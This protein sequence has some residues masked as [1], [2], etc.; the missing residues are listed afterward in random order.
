MDARTAF[1]GALL[2]AL[3]SIAALLVAPLLQYV[4]AA[5]LL[6]FVLYPVHQRL[7][8]RV[9]ERV[10]GLALTAFA[11]V[12]AVVPI[13]FFSIILLQTTFDFLDGFDELAAIET[14]REAAIDAGIEEEVLASIEAELLSE[15]EGSIGGAV[16][17]VLME[18]V[19]LLN[20]SVRMSFG[21]LVLVFVLYYLLVDGRTFVAWVSAVTPLEDDVRE[22]LFDEIEVVTWAV[23]QSHVLVALVEGMLGGL[24]FYL[25]GVPNVTFWMV[26]MIIVSFLP[27]IGVWLVWGPAVIYLAIT[28]DPLQAV[29]L[30][31]YG[32]AV[33]SVV[34]NY[35][36]ALF[37]DHGSG[38]HP[39]VVLVGVIGGIYLLGIMGLFLGPVLLAVFKAGLTV[40]S[41]VTNHGDEQVTLSSSETE[42]PQPE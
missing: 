25:L 22:E 26:V 21:M 3:G 20:A 11:I 19:G 16:E 18:I 33:L 4:M 42:P 8:K 2:V 12:A 37:V 14:L 1:F 24:G 40:F 5:G 23:I 39:A 13:L 7:E 28:A 34:D 27:A 38:L 6:A 15:I 17:V 9:D 36:R 32:I 29:V 31:T 30:F 41:R 35:L 10:S